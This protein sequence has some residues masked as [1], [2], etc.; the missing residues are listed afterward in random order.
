MGV[1]RRGEHRPG[2]ALRHRGL[3]RGLPGL[4]GEAEAGV[5]RP[6][7]SRHTPPPTTAPHPSR[8]GRGAVVVPARPRHIPVISPDRGVSHRG[9]Y[10]VTGVTS[11]PIGREPHRPAAASRAAA[12]PHPRSIHEPH[13]RIPRGARPRA[14]SPRGAQGHR[15]H[16]RR[17]HRRVVRLLHLRPGHRARLRRPLLPADG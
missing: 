6:R 11:R 12:A 8:E 7:L 4:P 17:H 5:H 1:P 16:R 13:R 10:T 3:R 9:S 14:R 15:R 2:R